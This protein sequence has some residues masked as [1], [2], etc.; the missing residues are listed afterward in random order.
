MFDP[1]YKA[2]GLLSA[3][4]AIIAMVRDGEH[5]LDK[6]GREFYWDDDVKI[7][8]YT[9]DAVNDAGKEYTVRG[10]NFPL[11]DLYRCP[12]RRK[13]PMTRWEVLD[14]ANSKAGRGWVVCPAGDGVSRPP[15]VWRPPQFYGYD[16][17]VEYYQ[18]ARLLPDLSGVDESTIQGFEVEE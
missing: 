1:D 10:S 7:F 5:L 17:G 18:R 6:D 2:D 11:P 16:E 14:W 3:K 9:L 13:R 8:W 4:D 15:G 12:S